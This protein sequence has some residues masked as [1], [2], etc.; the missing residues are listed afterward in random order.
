MPVPWSDVK[1]FYKELAG[2]GYRGLILVNT[3]DVREAISELS[4]LVEGDCLLVATKE[5][6]SG[7]CRASY[8]PLDI[9]KVLGSEYRAAVIALESLLR[10]NV[11]AAVTEV[12]RGGGFLAIVAPPLDKWN[13]GPHAGTGYYKRYLLSSVTSSRAHLWVTDEGV[14]SRSLDVGG[15]PP[16]RAWEFKSRKGVPRALMSLA[17]T[18]DQAK[19]L[20]AMAH[21]L[22]GRYRSVLV[23][24]DRGRG[25][26]YAVGLSL[27][28]AIYW[29]VVGRA[30]VVAPT[31]YSVASLMRGLIDGLE[32][33]GLRR[34]AKTVED[35]EGNVVRVSGPWFRVSYEDP[36]S[37]QPA[38]LTIIDE[39]AAVGV[40][41]V[42]RLSWRGGKT[43]A[44]TT[45][46]GY[47]GSGRVFERLLHQIL[48]KPMIEVSLSEPIRYPSGD[49]L[50][51]WV[52]TTFMLRAEPPSVGESGVRGV[53]H[54]VL[55]KQV[56]AS[57]RELLSS[58][59]GVLVQAHYRNMP[60]DLLTLLESRHHVVHA[61][62]AGSGLVVAVADV[63]Y[64]LWDGDPDSRIVLERLRLYVPE[65]ADTWSVRVSRIAVIP[66]L[67][68]RGLGSLLL[69]RVEEWASRE[70]ADMVTTMFSRH[71]VIGFWLKNGYRPVYVS[72]RF[73]RVTGEKN[74]AM[75]KPLTPRG[76]KVV[77][78][79]SS[80]LRAR[81]LLAGHSVY[82]DLAAEKIAAMIRFTEP[83]PLKL[84]TPE[85][86]SERLDMYFS[87]EIDME[88][89]M[90]IIYP[91]VVSR[92]SNMSSDE[93]AKLSDTELVAVIA[94]LIQGK[95]L[96]EVATLLGVNVSEAHNIVDGAVRKL[97]GRS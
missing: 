79:A 54:V 5:Y 51:E 45:I 71:D 36:E 31:P 21:F 26:S 20:E 38:P 17:A 41:R 9:D 50:E 80:V 95:P 14:I 18:L 35:S 69:R 55:D 65:A 97:L 40:A 96:N 28:L 47:E 82:R 44:S 52:Y 93:L 10:P 33:L 49:P 1:E 23:K 29:H 67:Q 66:E 84:G 83:H 92:L 37:V 63:V 8:G 34:V 64:E 59:Y 81:L 6:R 24:G 22:H 19:A 58:V 90:D 53:T 4:S 72:P 7:S 76:D 75:A 61:L 74:V 27:A 85:W 70:G 86:S 32:A 57:D 42:R 3:S 15:R 91:L 48:P 46:H 87:G 88:Q 12:V 60:D 73:N 56:L 13:P 89:A 39:A 62:R 2:S 68:G 30:V 11:V 25:K 94:R 77:R 16:R 78:K 43:V